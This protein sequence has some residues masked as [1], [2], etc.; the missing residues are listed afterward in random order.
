MVRITDLWKESFCC[1]SCHLIEDNSRISAL[2]EC[3]L[4]STGSSLVTDC[5]LAHLDSG[6]GR[7]RCRFC[8]ETRDQKLMSMCFC[9]SQNELNVFRIGWWLCETWRRLQLHSFCCVVCLMTAAVSVLQFNDA[10]G[11]TCR[12]KVSGFMSYLPCEAASEPCAA[13]S[14]CFPHRNRLIHHYYYYFPFLILNVC[15]L[16]NVIVWW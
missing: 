13:L 5:F 11:W 14:V 6:G 16:H 3:Y 10:F 4:A 1:R 2:A 7:R 9:V 8:G 12:N 15:E